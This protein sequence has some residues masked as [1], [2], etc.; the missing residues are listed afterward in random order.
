MTSES[1]KSRL[2]TNTDDI[3]FR[4]MRSIDKPSKH[5]SVPI[6]LSDGTPFQ[7][8]VPRGFTFGLKADR[9]K[10][11]PLD[12]PIKGYT[13][14]IALSDR[15][16]QNAE[17]AKVIALIKDVV[18]KCR[19]HLSS[20]SVKLYG[21]QHPVTSF[22]DVSEN[23]PL[24]TRKSEDNTTNPENPDKTFYAKCATKL[25][26]AS[27]VIT[28]DTSFY[29]ASADRKRVADPIADFYEKKGHVRAVVRVDAIF[30]G[31]KAV[32][33]VQF[34]VVEAII[35]LQGELYSEMLLPR[36]EIIPEAANTCASQKRSIG[37]CEDGGGH[38][39]DDDD[40]E[41]EEDDEE[42]EADG[43]TKPKHLKSM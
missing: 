31:S 16:I 41:E 35:E 18:N 12:S 14:P 6:S 21:R 7:F 25:N 27:G 36:S 4:Q 22:A 10:D 32:T 34:R 40:E 3:F 1:P 43:A 19:Q 39:D 28:F 33:A 20:V 15:G 8:A 24:V 26:E 23:S 29:H 42:E 2:S 30:V 17:Q 11:A 38:G 9:G 5:M 37:A 13:L